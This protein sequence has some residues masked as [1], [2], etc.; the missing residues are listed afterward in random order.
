LQL[1][2]EEGAFQCCPGNDD[3]RLTIAASSR[4]LRGIVCHLCKQPLGAAP[5]LTA[6]SDVSDSDS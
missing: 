1:A 3:V 4:E 5:G 6:S 2:M